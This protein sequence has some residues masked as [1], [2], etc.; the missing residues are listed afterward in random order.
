MYIW[1]FFKKYIN[2]YNL[3]KPGVFVKHECPRW[4][5]SPK[6]AIFSKKVTV[7]VTRSLTFVSFEKLQ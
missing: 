5:Q 7:K 4:Q 2:K 6:L 1:E 3:K